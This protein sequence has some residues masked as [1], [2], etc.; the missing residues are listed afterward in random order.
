[1]I[2]VRHTLGTLGRWSNPRVRVTPSPIEGGTSGKRKGGHAN[3]FTR[4]PP[5]KFICSR[6]G[7]TNPPR[8]LNHSV[9]KVKYLTYLIQAFSGMDA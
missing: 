9:P 3:L 8:I 6:A 5:P 2:L 1:M 7:K 4:D